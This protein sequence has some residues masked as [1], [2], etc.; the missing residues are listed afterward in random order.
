M[1]RSNKEIE[2]EIVALDECKKYVP[3]LNFFGENNH[4]AIDAGVTALA[5]RMSVDDAYDASGGDEPTAEDNARI[6][7]AQ[8]MAGDID[9]APSKGW[10]S[11]KK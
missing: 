7:A 8:W 10:A 1:K 6:E 9:D 2:A 4:D 11:F 5:E 3:K